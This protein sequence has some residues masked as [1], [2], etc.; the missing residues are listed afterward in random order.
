MMEKLFIGDIKIP[1]AGQKY[2][3]PIGDKFIPLIETE[4][5]K[6]TETT[7]E[8][9]EMS[10]E[11]SVESE[12]TNAGEEEKVI[13]VELEE[14]KSRLRPPKMIL[15]DSTAE[16][17]TWQL[18]EPEPKL[19]VDKYQVSCWDHL[20]TNHQ[21]DLPCCLV[22]HSIELVVNVVCD[23]GGELRGQPDGGPAGAEHLL[24]LPGRDVGGGRGVAL[25]TEG[26]EDDS[27]LLSLNLCKLL[28]TRLAFH[29]SHAKVPRM[30]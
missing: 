22:S 4:T 28:Y 20:T 26:S 10:K 5:T 8:K 29:Q 3:E 16:S 2:M 17:I 27:G 13:G 25:L 19:K 24:H 1:C 23:Q 14:K 18:S 12:L 11:I 15:L 6:D 30:I 9:K 21:R 7:R